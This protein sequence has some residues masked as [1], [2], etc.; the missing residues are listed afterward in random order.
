MCIRLLKFA[1]VRKH[2]I[3]KIWRSVK[4]KAKKKRKIRENYLYSHLLGKKIREI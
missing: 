4:K 1:R 2:I 3:I